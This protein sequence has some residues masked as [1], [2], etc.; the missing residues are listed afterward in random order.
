MN[1]AIRKY[2]TPNNA[3]SA[4]SDQIISQYC[5]EGALGPDVTL[6]TV[7]QNIMGK[8]YKSLTLSKLAV[9]NNGVYEVY[10]SNVDRVLILP[11]EYEK[12]LNDLSDLRTVEYVK[13]V[14]VCI[15]GEPFRTLM[16]NG[17][18]TNEFDLRDCI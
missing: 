2:N 8:A 9:L 17:I 16:R 11:K 10:V 7:L 14:G 13:S 4:I 12:Y 6:K 1:K 18:T 15:H 5:A 3:I